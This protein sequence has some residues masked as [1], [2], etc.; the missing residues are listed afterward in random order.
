MS[1]EGFIR[2]APKVELHLHIEGTL[3]PELLMALAERH[4]IELPYTSVDQ[5][6][7]AYRFTNLQSFL[8]IYYQ[9]AAV[10]REA[11]DFAQLTWAYLGRMAAE[12]VR[13]VEI[14]FDPQTHTQ[15][16]V[17]FD[18]VVDG[19]AASL[20]RAERELGITSGLIACLLRHLGPAAGESTVDSVLR[21]PDAIVGLGLDS[22][23][24]C[25]PPQPFAQLFRRVRAHGLRTVAHAGEE[26]PPAFVQGALD[27]LHAERI[28]HG[29]RALEDPA[30]VARLA[31]ERVPLTVCPLS[32]LALRVIERLDQ[33]PL[34]QLLD[35]Q[36]VATVNSDDPAYFGGY[37]T[38]NLVRVTAA[39]HLE[40]A[41][42]TTLLQNSIQ[43]SFA[44]LERKNTLLNELASL[45]TSI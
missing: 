15:R 10:L 42:V 14:F 7:E 21:R 39:L 27:A 37:L 23:E 12:N 33:H 34:K 1:L 25:Y 32:N 22:S 6:R 5:V 41:E 2:A 24:R 11:E 35:A 30:L 3:E 20:R 38:D 8:D 29:I 36:I 43:V 16:G 26:G 19:I 31:A 9:G 4:S 13:H 40:P 44:S 45:S 17:R 18:T 28:D